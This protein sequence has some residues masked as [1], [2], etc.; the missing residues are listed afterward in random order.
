MCD[1]TKELNDLDH[2]HKYI[3]TVNKKVVAIPGDSILNGIDQHGLSNES[4]KVRVRNHPGATT[5]DICRHLKPEIQKKPDVVIIHVGASDLT[6]NSKS[7][8]NYK[9]MAD[10]IRFKLPNGKLAISNV[11]T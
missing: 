7:L 9:R 11:I 3:N 1:K 5:E 4:F 10:S 2:N 6:S 8:E